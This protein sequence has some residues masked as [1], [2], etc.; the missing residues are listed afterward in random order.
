MVTESSWFVLSLWNTFS[1]SHTVESAA[2][3]LSGVSLGGPLHPLNLEFYHKSGA[4]NYEFSRENFFE[5]PPAPFLG[6]IARRSFGQ[7]YISAVIRKNR[8]ELSSLMGVFTMCGL[9]EDF[10]NTSKHKQVI[11]IWV[12]RDH[13][14]IKPE[15]QALWPL[16]RDVS[17]CYFQAGFRVR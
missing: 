10:L 4:N 3:W 11:L 14:L 1:V 8:Q 7:I 5:T 12:W 16:V 9:F 15:L 13:W 17:L 2:R 6:D